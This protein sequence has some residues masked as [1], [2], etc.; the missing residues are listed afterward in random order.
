MLRVHGRLPQRHVPVHPGGSPPGSIRGGRVLTRDPVG[1][2]EE[3]EE[4]YTQTGGD[5]RPAGQSEYGR[6]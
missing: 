4:G 6:Q 2:G 5:T 1:C 3:E